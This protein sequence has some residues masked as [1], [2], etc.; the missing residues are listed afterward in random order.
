MTKTVLLIC[1]YPVDTVPGQRLKYEQY[2]PLLSKL[3]YSIEVQPF[4]TDHQ[5]R[6]LY[7]KGNILPKVI[8]VISGIFRRT[9]LL[10]RVP[11]FDGIYIFLNVVPLGPPLLEYI[12]LKLAKASIYDI[13]DMVHLLPTT[14][15][16]RLATPF[17]T[18]HRFTVLLKGADHVITCT[19]TL[20]SIAR[21]YNSNTTDISSTVNTSRYLPAN[22]YSASKSLVIGWSG[23]HSTSPYLHLL[24]RVFRE[25]SKVY[26][27]T[28]LVIGSS[29]YQLPGVRLELVPW[30]PETE[31]PSLQRIDIGVYPL[32]D[33]PWVNGKSGL[34]A[35]Q[36]MALGI[37]T[38]ASNLG[39]NSRVVEHGVSGFLAS[40]YD[41]WVSILSAL[42][43]DHH[44]RRSIGLAARHRAESLFSVD[45]NI[46]KYLKVFDSTYL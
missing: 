31:I 10:F 35:I 11:S 16:N 4:F 25:L 2:L 45:A 21:R 43:D 26:D 9:L 22:Q 18:R 12:Y 42:I 19:P 34:K 32:P 33:E 36:Y 3:G 46:S 1:P 41:D 17:K 6:V 44:L 37:P 5:Y 38:V 28:L 40:S 7:S 15:V 39:C 8:A 13:D 14:S 29:D 20:D 30:S 24:D 23:S 27:F